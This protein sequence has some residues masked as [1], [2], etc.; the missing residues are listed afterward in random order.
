MRSISPSRRTWSTPASSSAPPTGPQRPQTRPRS[1]P[2]CAT[3]GSGNDLRLESVLGTDTCPDWDTFV[4]RRTDPAF[5]DSWNWGACQ[6]LADAKAEGF[7]TMAIFCYMPPCL[8][9]N[10]S[11]PPKGDAERWKAFQDVCAET[12]RRY[13]ADIDVIE[14]FN[15]THFFTKAEGSGYARSVEA[16]P[17]IYHAV[18]GALG[19]VTRKPI[20]GPATWIDCWAG[21][22]L[23]TLPF[24]SRS[25][26][27]SMGYFSI[28]IY[29]TD[30]QAFLDRIDH[31]REVLDGARPDLPESYSA[32]LRGTPV[33]ITE[34]NQYWEGPRYGMD[35]Y[36]FMLTEMLRRNAPNVI[37]NYNEFFGPSNLAAARPWRVL[38]ES[39]LNARAQRI[40]MHLPTREPAPDCVVTSVAATLPDRSVVVLAANMA[41]EPAPI[42]W[43]LN[44]SPWSHP[45]GLQARVWCARGDGLALA[46]DG[47]DCTRQLTVRR[48]RA[49][50]SATLPPHSFTVLRISSDG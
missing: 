47:D 30:P 10:G 6:W 22:G 48:S 25:R 45:A 46:A 31:T 36:G 3:T 34:W 42:R 49:A 18:R 19:P 4:S 27:G 33:W 50:L 15:E 9:A 38:L 35:W 44:N 43:S 12:Y 8:T 24:D 20:I 37:Y 40:A 13:G 17:D 26:P 21:S 2:S 7:R 29:D 1:C 39:G 5:A 41:D 16:D 11:L 32:P 28:H 23:E 14:S